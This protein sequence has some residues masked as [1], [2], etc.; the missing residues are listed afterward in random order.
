MYKLI[1]AGQDA[2][3]SQCQSIILNPMG[4]AWFDLCKWEIIQTPTKSFDK[5]NLLF[6]QRV[7]KL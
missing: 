3:E 1:S 4:V 5:H 2:L 7:K 6:H